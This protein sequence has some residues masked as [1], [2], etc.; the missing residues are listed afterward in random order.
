MVNLLTGLP[1]LVVNCED[2]GNNEDN[3]IDSSHVDI[4]TIDDDDG[5]T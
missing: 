2:M 5:S 1:E 4:V 3:Q